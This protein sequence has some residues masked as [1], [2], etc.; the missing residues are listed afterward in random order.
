MSSPTNLPSVAPAFVSV[1]NPTSST[2]HEPVQ[3]NPASEKTSGPRHQLLIDDD[4]VAYIPGSEDLHLKFLRVYNEGYKFLHPETEAGAWLHVIKNSTGA[5]L[6]KARAAHAAVTGE[7]AKAASERQ[8][9]LNRQAFI[10][11]LRSLQELVKIALRKVDALA[12]AALADEVRLFN[13]Y[14][15]K[16]EHTAVY[17]RVVALENELKAMQNSLNE[18]GHVMAMNANRETGLTFLNWFRAE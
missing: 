13:S 15:L 18:G 10:P 3:I 5:E 14:G 16:H 17:R 7:G 11:F 8:R 6:E 4:I 12:Q 9:E 2:P 1:Y